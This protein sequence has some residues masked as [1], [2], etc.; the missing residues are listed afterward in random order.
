MAND[1]EAAKAFADLIDALR[2]IGAVDLVRDIQAKVSRGATRPLA[3][4]RRHEK[5]TIQAPLTP[6]EAFVLAVRHIIASLDPPFMLEQTRKLLQEFGCN[7]A[8]DIVWEYDRLEQTGESLVLLPAAEEYVDPIR[9]VPHLELEDAQNLRR[10]VANL[11]GL[12]EAVVAAE[13]Q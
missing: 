10:A 4:P 13:E 3:E 11:I 6:T 12:C 1:H 2:T 7:D 8:V 5:V 9:K